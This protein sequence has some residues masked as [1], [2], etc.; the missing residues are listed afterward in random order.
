MVVYLGYVQL[1][2]NVGIGVQ[3]QLS[4]EGGEVVE[5][6]ERLPEQSCD[7][8]P[9]SRVTQLKLPQIGLPNPCPCVR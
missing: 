4:P 7:V 5:T 2:V 9:L 6:A 3:C 1:D 8:F